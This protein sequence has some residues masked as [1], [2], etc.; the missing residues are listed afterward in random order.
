[1]LWL[2]GCCC[3]IGGVIFIGK[4]WGKIRPMIE[5]EEDGVSYHAGVSHTK[6]E[7]MIPL[8]KDDLEIDSSFSVD[9][10]TFAGLSNKSQLK[11]KYGEMG[12]TKKDF[13]ERLLDAHPKLKDKIERRKKKE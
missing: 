7:N 9:K 6:K 2:I 3:F 12:K 1:M 13:D 4:V 11:I 10:D 5:I 8:T